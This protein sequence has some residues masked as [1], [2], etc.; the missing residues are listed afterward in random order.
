MTKNLSLI[1]TNVNQLSI[2]EKKHIFDILVDSKCFYSH[3]KNGYFF[4]LYKLD[5]KTV[6]KISDCID[7][8]HRHRTLITEMDTRREE[9]IIHYKKLI[10]QKLDKKDREYKDTLYNKLVLKDIVSHII[11]TIEKQIVVR[12]T[13]T[14]IPF[15]F[16]PKHKWYSLHQKLKL[17]ERMTKKKTHTII[18]KSAKDNNEVEDEGELYDMY[19]D[20]DIDVDEEKDAKKNDSEHEYESESESEQSDEEIIQENKELSNILS[21]NTHLLT[22]EDYNSLQQYLIT[23]H[24]TTLI[25]KKIN[26]CN[27][28]KTE[29]VIFINIE[30]KMD[31]Y[32]YILIKAG[33]VFNLVLYQEKML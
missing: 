25:R 2:K 5:E 28:F 4:D 21:K 31:M 29:Q 3:N 13:C 9:E 23:E 27:H 22:K 17:M 18:I 12:T 8:I 26:E 20:V 16:T 30:K 14:Y 24:E 11:Y 19:S 32:K 6:K 33:F 1:I 7:L 15:K 10:I